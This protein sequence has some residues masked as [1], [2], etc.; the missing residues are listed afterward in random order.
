MS[1]VHVGRLA[2]A[3]GFGRIV[4]IKQLHPH[5]ASQREFVAML[6]DEARLASRIRHPNVVSVSDVVQQ[7]GQLLLVMDYVP[8]VSLAELIRL[9][10]ADQRRLPLP[11]VSAIGSG[12]LHGLHAAHEATDERGRALGI[13]HRDVSPQ[14]IL[15]GADGVARVVDFGV[16]KAVGRLNTTADGQVKGKMAYMAPEQLRSGAVDRRA[17]VY[18][19]ALVLWEAVT[20]ARPFD[21]DDSPFARIADDV[22]APSTLAPGIPAALDALL[23]RALQRTPEHRTADARVMALELEAAVPPASAVEVAAL[24]GALAA[25]LLEER[26]AMVAGAESGPLP[27]TASQESAGSVA[28][29]PGREPPPRARRRTVAVAVVGALLAV[30]A[31]VLLLGRGSGRAPMAPATVQAQAA[32][33]AA[34]PARVAPV[35]AAVEPPA[36]AVAPVSTYDVAAV[37]IARGARTAVPATLLVAR[38]RSDA[39]RRRLVHVRGKHRRRT[40]VALPQPRAPRANC[41]PPFTIGPDGVKQYKIECL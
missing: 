11:I 26:A 13:V 20:L 24:V 37:P 12:A 2:G 35:S 23:E 29:P 17:D 39:Q 41:V 25:D 18:A 31:G 8:G 36:T 33:G 4:A 7:D 3:A 32:A 6:L 5:L 27:G 1:S 19:A 14:N 16:A 22:P 15:V 30:S 38:A 9:A 34:V 21:G 28:P 40:V 10:E